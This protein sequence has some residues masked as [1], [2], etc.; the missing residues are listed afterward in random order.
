MAAELDSVPLQEDLP[1]DAT[2]HVHRGEVAA[3]PWL[4]AEEREQLRVEAIAAAA[5]EEHSRQSN[6]GRALQEMLGG[7][8]ACACLWGC[9][10][11][12]ASEQGS[13]CRRVARQALQSA[14]GTARD[15]GRC[16]F[17][18][19]G[20]P[21]PVS[22]SWGLSCLDCMPA[23]IRCASVPACVSQ[24]GPVLPLA[25]MACPSAL[26]QDFSATTH[27]VLWPNSC[28]CMAFSVL[29]M[30]QAQLRAPLRPD[31][32]VA[33]RPLLLTGGW[34]RSPGWRSLMQS[35][36]PSRR[37]P[38][39]TLSRNRRYGAVLAFDALCSS[40]AHCQQEGTQ[41][42]SG[43]KLNM[44]C[45][46][47][48]GALHTKVLKSSL[49]SQAHHV[50]KLH[51]AACTHLSFAAMLASVLQLHRQDSRQGLSW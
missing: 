44:G 7:A 49:P 46:S 2:L 15:A 13:S 12:C 11:S 8:Q 4:T 21:G 42:E 20:G 33:A 39:L 10:W 50:A 27:E 35:S 31:E 26:I 30:V 18:C 3:Q 28:L 48:I 29:P 22:C 36:L 6:V 41:A 19:L 37:P 40:R 14:R 1:A 51:W 16:S 32:G 17:S 45:C 24:Q 38:R 25:A 9:A 23:A 43:K 5:A 47:R 34:W